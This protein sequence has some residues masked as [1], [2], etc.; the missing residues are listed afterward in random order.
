MSGPSDKKQTDIIHEISATGL[1]IEDQGHPA[2]YVGVTI[3]KHNNGCIEFTQ[4][5]LIHAIIEDVHIGDAYTKPVP[6][7]DMHQLHG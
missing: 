4:Q 5:A 2:D 1:D 6:A 3:T 7:K